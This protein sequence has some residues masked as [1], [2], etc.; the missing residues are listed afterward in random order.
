MT[1]RMLGIG[2]SLLCLGDEVVSS[3]AEGLPGY[4]RDFV[5]EIARFPASLVAPRADETLGVGTRKLLYYRVAYAEN[6][7][8]PVS[9]V[10]E[11]E[12]WADMLEVSEYFQR[13]SRGIFTLEWTITSLLVLP[14]EAGHYEK[15]DGPD[16]ILEH[17]RAAALAAGHDFQEYDFDLVRVSAIAGSEAG[18]LG[19]IGQRGAWVERPG[20]V[21]I[22]HELGHNLGFHH[23]N[24]WDTRTP[25][26]TSRRFHPSDAKEEDLSAYPR[27]P[28]GMIGR[29]SIIGPGFSSEYGDPFDLM[30][31]GGMPP[32]NATY[33]H[34]AGW[35]GVPRI[36]DASGSGVYRLHA[37]D[38]DTLR[39]DR[40]YAVRVENWRLESSGPQCYWIQYRHQPLTNRPP[41]EGVLLHWAPRDDHG[42]PTL[43]LDMAPGGADKQNDS[44]LK[45]GQTFSDP[46]VDL[47]ITPVARGESENGP[48][49]DVVVNQGLFPENSAPVLTLGAVAA[50]ASPDETMI[51][52]AAASD[53]DGDSLSWFWDFGDG[54]HASTPGPVEKA[55]P[56]EGDY[57]TRCEISDRK[58]GR[59]SAHFVVRVGNPRTYTVSGQV[60]DSA[61]HAVA[62]ALVHNGIYARNPGSANYRHTLTDSA[63]RYTLTGIATGTYSN[64]AFHLGYSFAL[65]SANPVVH[66]T[67]ASVE[68][69]DFLASALPTVTLSVEKQEIEEG[70]SVSVSVTRSHRIEEPLNVLIGAGGGT[71]DSSD[72]LLEG[73][74]LSEI[75]P[76]RQ[77]GYELQFPPGEASAALTLRALADGSCETNETVALAMLWPHQLT[78]ENGN[79]V[80]TVPI[81]GWELQ[82]AYGETMWVQ[83][84]SPYVPGSSRKTVTITDP[85]MSLPSLSI[86]ASGVA[87]EMPLVGAEFIIS[88]QGCRS[89]DLRVPYVTS[90]TALNGVDYLTLSGEILISSNENIAFIEITPIEDPFSEGTETVEILLSGGEG[91]LLENDHAQINIKD[92]AVDPDHLEAVLGLDG[93]V[94]IWTI[95]QPGRRHI[96]ESSVN[97]LDWSPVKTNIFFTDRA[98][99]AID[100][101]MMK[102]GQFFRSRME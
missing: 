89:G 15:P 63:G 96:L 17:A 31:A 46:L 91:Y 57:V 27:H 83:S 71:V 24:F 84:S 76:G 55:W 35:L 49:I 61:G 22:A 21:I 75:S 78:R 100:H 48:W 51:I 77:R 62:D 40:T 66:V 4:G 42:G 41:V 18:G 28:A 26:I 72:F 8:E 19:R 94:T 50:T 85:P 87:S 81:P 16:E 45:I 79:N 92:Q 52:A 3:M 93:R 99:H 43:L 67:N 90:G 37:L 6:R 97:L 30:G 82:E 73:A 13:T 39:P 60:R 9:P 102:A 11:T 58:G 7:G 65:P 25:D 88:V 14:H 86:S 29:E 56:E 53:P 70:G 101:A 34:H 44:T 23:A 10:S 64:A 98:T 32:V 59:T 33:Q 74:W 12:A 2:L 38:T 54:T 47:H 20:P 36:A 5:C 68:N 69:L 1:Q 95:G 80:I